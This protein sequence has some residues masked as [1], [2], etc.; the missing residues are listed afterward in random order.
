MQLSFLDGFIET[1]LSVIC[2]EVW[3]FDPFCR[4]STPM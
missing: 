4:A 2:W 3:P 1:Q